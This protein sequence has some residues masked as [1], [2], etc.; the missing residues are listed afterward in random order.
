ML[1]AEGNTLSI[2]SYKKIVSPS[3]DDLAPE[4]FCKVKGF[5]SHQCKIVAIGSELEMKKIKTLEE[6]DGTGDGSKD[7]AEPPPQKKRCVEKASK[8][9]KKDKENNIKTPSR[10][11][12]VASSLLPLKTKQPQLFFLRLPR[13]MSMPHHQVRPAI[14][15]PFKR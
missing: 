8:W 4:T 6:A 3:Q 10:P 15:N 13:T 5:E 7:L 12:K 14:S 2:V 9:R 11:K 1:C